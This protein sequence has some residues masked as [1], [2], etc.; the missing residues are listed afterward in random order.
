MIRI[1]S[2]N[3]VRGHVERL[4]EICRASAWEELWVDLSIEVCT[5]LDLGLEENASDA[6]V[7]RT[8]QQQNVVLITGNRNADA[9][10]S[11]EVTIR[12][13]GGATSLP[14]LTISNRE[15][16]AR[17]RSYAESVLVRLIEI[18]ME[19]EELRGA[20]RLFLP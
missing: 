6:T 3:D 5:L 1:V 7:W 15:R 14:V 13:E 12:N 16:V 10:D 11:L 8:C 9:A 4:V 2:D 19:L 18:L 17:D 20:G